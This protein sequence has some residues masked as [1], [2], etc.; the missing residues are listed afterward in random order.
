MIAQ[1]SSSQR[2]AFDR[3][4]RDFSAV[5]TGGL[6]QFMADVLA[7]LAAG[8]IGITAD[9]ADVD[10]IALGGGAFSVNG[11]T[12]SGLTFGYRGGRIWNGNA[13][14]SV[15]AGTVALSGSTTNYVEV[16]AAGVVSANTSGFTAGAIPLYEVVTSSGAISTTSSRKA[17]LSINGDGRVTGKQ[18][19]TAARTKRLTVQLGTISATSSFRVILPAHVGTIAR[20]SIAVG[21]TVSA[22]D[23][24]FWTFAL[25]NKEAGGA[26][27]TATLAATDA[28]TT[29]ATGGSAI[30]ADIKRNLTLHGTA[31]NLN[32]AAEDVLV[33]TATK[34]ASAANLVEATL[35][36]DITFEA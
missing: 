6:S 32:T 29:K 22:N 15:S 8:T 27:T 19:S 34:T 35:A 33:F 12:T 10:S 11:D 4:A 1:L 30:T 25:V 2:A 31:G 16:S 21:T 13:F 24:N 36:I 17:L 28:N 23:T 5:Y 18:L 14:V 26:G 3:M 20:V 9:A 7:E